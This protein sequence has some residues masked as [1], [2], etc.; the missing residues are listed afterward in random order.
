MT[1]CFCMFL[2]SSLSPSAS[3]FCSLIIANVHLA[4]DIAVSVSQCPGLSEAG[5]GNRAGRLNQAKW[6]IP[7]C[8]VSRQTVELSDSRHLMVLSDKILHC[9]RERDFLNIYSPFVQCIFCVHIYINTHTY[10]SIFFP[11]SFLSSCY[12]SVSSATSEAIHQL[13]DLL[14]VQYPV[15]I[16]CCPLL[17]S[18]FLNI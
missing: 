16:Y 3:L 14:F 18:R 2:T 13:E 5:Q 15:K 8:Q 7:A 6:S 17:S 12:V 1:V 9:S 4:V 10:W 11:V